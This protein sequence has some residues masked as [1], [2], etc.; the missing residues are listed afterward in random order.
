MCSGSEAGSYLRLIDSCITQLTAQGPV[1]RVKKIRAL[2]SS[3]HARPC[4]LQGL[5]PIPSLTAI[6]TGSGRGTHFS[7]GLA[8]GERTQNKSQ[9][10]LVAIPRQESHRWL[11]CGFSSS[12]RTSLC[13]PGVEVQ[14][15]GE[16]VEGRVWGGLWYLSL[17][18]V[19]EQR[20][21]HLWT[22]DVGP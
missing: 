16:R 13:S 3:A 20:M 11:I 5:G 18:V 8:R 12:A 7:T 22:Y 6:C 1:T 19:P 14:G 17:D 10:G 21:N 9:K 4:V 2:S 15:F